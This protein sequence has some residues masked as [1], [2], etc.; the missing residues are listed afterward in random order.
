MTKLFKK[1]TWQFYY[2]ITMKLHP[3]ET[4]GLTMVNFIVSHSRASLA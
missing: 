3:R 4:E 1:Y 2:E